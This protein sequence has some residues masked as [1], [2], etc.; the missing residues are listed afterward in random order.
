MTAARLIGLLV[1]LIG[2]L[3]GALLVA[4]PFVA[5]VEADPLVMGL[6][7]TVCLAF[8]LPLYASGSGRVEALRIAAA[9]LLGLGVFSLLGIFVDGTGLL[10]ALRP[11][12]VLWLMVPAGLLG[13]LLLNYFAGALE[14]VDPAPR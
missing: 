10:A 1:F 7:F 4:L 2:V 8:G 14:R 11:L 6:L 12:Y 9:A 13:G 5:A 3:S